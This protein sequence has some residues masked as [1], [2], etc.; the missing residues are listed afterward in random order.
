LIAHRAKGAVIGMIVDP[1]AA[2][3]AAALG[4]GAL[5]DCGV[6]AKVGYAGETPVEAEWRIVRVGSGRFTGTGPMYGGAKFQ[7]GP[8]ALITDEASGVSAV[9]ASKRIQANDKEMFRHVGV[10][11]AEV[12]ILGLKSTVHFRADFQPIAEAVLCVQSPGAHV[13]DPTELPYRNLRPGIRLR[14][15]SLRTGYFRIFIREFFLAAAQATEPCSSPVGP[16]QIRL[17]SI[18]PDSFQ[19]A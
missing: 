7:I 17:R 3:R 4:E 11:P 16:L 5:L 18:Y 19:G 15:N 13:S 2:E 10:E 1:E 12:P 6:G 9:L 8:M 14:P